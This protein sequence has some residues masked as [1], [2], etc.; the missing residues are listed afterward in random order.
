MGTDNIQN[1][2][3]D[4]RIQMQITQQHLA[5]ALGV[6]RQTVIAIEKGNYVPS[7]SLALKAGK[8][9]NKPVEKIFY[10]KH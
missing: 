3:H 5:D 6:T 7:V 1:K 10:V 4:L 8:F 9:F 2:V